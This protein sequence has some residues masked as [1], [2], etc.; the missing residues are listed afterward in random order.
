VTFGDYEHK[1]EQLGSP[2]IVKFY[3]TFPLNS[4]EFKD[5]SNSHTSDAEP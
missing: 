3:Q 1:M 4:K 2:G 5:H